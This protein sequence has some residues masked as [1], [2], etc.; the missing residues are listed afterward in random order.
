MRDYSWINH[1]DERALM[2][3][4][5]PEQYRDMVDIVGIP[6]FLG[7]CDMWGGASHCFPTVANI[8]SQ[9]DGAISVL[10]VP[11]RDRP[12]VALLGLPK[13]LD[14]LEL[15]G[16]KQLYIP[17]KTTILR[18]ARN[19]I[20]RE[21]YSIGGQSARTLARKYGITATAMTRICTGLIPKRKTRPKM[22][23]GR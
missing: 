3:S 10:C 17:F 15:C 6:A 8:A 2:P 4:M 16:G 7:L 21:E 11:E 19:Q 1:T 18:P 13:Y 23:I 5:I 9:S 22:T 12:A 14:L 20:I